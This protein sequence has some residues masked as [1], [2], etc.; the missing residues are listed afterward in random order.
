M[1]IVTLA[2]ALQLAGACPVIVEASAAQA[3][4]KAAACALA[5]FGIAIDDVVIGLNTGVEIFRPEHHPDPAGKPLFQDPPQPVCSDRG[6][7]LP[8]RT[9]YL[10]QAVASERGP[11]TWEIT[12]HVL[13]NYSRSPR[14]VG[15]CTW[16]IRLLVERR[17]PNEWVV[18][19]ARLLTVC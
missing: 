11:D 6:C 2:L 19:G 13:T 17:G 7:A 15:M 10:R 18:P 9:G 16:R 5:E 8:G 3:T 12:A 4:A 1:S 14:S